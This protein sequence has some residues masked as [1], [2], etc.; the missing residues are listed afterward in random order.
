MC[1][2]QQTTALQRFMLFE[3]RVNICRQ[4]AALTLHDNVHILHYLHRIAV[5]KLA[6]SADVEDDRSAR[7]RT[8]RLYTSPGGYAKGCRMLNIGVFDA[9]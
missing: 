4:S 1:T 9:L 7:D 5:E 6:F 2:F 8:N 3:F